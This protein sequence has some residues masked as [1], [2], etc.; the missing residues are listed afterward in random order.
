ME[1][2]YIVYCHTNKINGKKYIGITKQKIDRRWRDGNGYKGQR[3]YLAINKYGWDNFF[4][5]ILY[6]N[7]SQEEARK[8]EKKLIED[9]DLKNR[10]KGYNNTDGGDI[11]PVKTRKINQFD[12]DGN[13]IKSYSS[14]REASK[15]LGI[16]EQNIGAVAR[17][18]KFKSGGY[19]W[20]YDDE[21]L[22]EY[23]F[24]AKKVD[25]Y[26]KDGEYIKTYNSELSVEKELGISQRDISKACRGI[27]KTAGG[28]K[29]AFHGQKLQS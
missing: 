11:P 20:T 4:H 14:I 1:N 28:F 24:Q 21:E 7:L 29:W 12:L 26:T 13:Y 3:F 23:S 5:E 8:I 22:K 27:N 18:K 6:E 25:Q 15:A 19:R 9:L 10:D 17:G 2:N 16:K